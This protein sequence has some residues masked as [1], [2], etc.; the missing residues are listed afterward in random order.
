MPATIGGSTGNEENL[1]AMS[2]GFNKSGKARRDD[3]EWLRRSGICG[4]LQAAY[5]PGNDTGLPDDLLKLCEQIDRA[6]DGKRA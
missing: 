6:T 2:T 4:A 1:F 3:G 5:E